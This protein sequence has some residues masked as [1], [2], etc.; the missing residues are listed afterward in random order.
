MEST[1]PKSYLPEMCHLSAFASFLIPFGQILGPL[2]MWLWKRHSDPAVNEHGREALNF[3]ISMTIY[4]FILVVLALGV[5]LATPLIAKIGVSNN[6]P[7]AAAVAPV[8]LAVAPILFL[9]VANVLLTIWA[10]IRANKGES[11]R[12]PLT[13]RFVR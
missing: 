2:G 10:A 3:Q 6:L 12:Y 11:V 4:S 13:L 5:A 7:F 9:F 8:F 1:A